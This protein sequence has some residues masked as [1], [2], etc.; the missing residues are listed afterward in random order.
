M[1]KK[2]LLEFVN[3][4]KV[5]STV[6]TEPGNEGDIYFSKREGNAIALRQGDTLRLLSEFKGV[7]SLVKKVQKS[8]SRWE[9]MGQPTQ[10]LLVDL[11]LKNVG[12]LNTKATQ[13]AKG[14]ALFEFVKAIS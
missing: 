4:A 5:T 14:E 2:T 13:K 7:I 12:G 9:N 1:M 3:E 6:F 10:E 8:D 11:A